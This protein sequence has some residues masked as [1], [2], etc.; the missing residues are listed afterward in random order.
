[1]DP[2]E[3]HKKTHTRLVAAQGG[4]VNFTARASICRA[5]KSTMSKST[6][7][8]AHIQAKRGDLVYHA[9]RNGFV[10]RCCV[11]LLRLCHLASL[12]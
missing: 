3:F 8:I 10:L 7:I 6:A 1:M 4:Y 12:R 2:L 11:T 9:R 5:F